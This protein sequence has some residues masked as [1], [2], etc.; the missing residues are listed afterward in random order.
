MG[1]PELEKVMQRRRADADGHAG[2]IRPNRVNKTKSS[3]GG[4]LEK[5]LAR[6]TQLLEEVR[7]LVMIEQ[8]TVRHVPSLMEADLGPHYIVSWTGKIFC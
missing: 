8:F 2:P 6:R 7:S 4:E 5:Q 1:K 3:C